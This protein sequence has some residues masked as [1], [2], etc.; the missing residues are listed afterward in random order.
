MTAQFSSS[1]QYCC[2]LNC[3]FRC[4]IPLWLIA[5][6]KE[7]QSLGL[8]ERS[9]QSFS[10][11]DLGVLDGPPE[12]GFDVVVALSAT[13]LNAPMVALVMIDDES[14]SIFLRAS[15][16]LSRNI[17]PMI[18]LPLTGS[19]ASETRAENQPVLINDL[20]RSDNTHAVEAVFLGAGA[21][22]GAPVHG[23][24]GEPIGA[25]LAMHRT[26][27]AWTKAQAQAVEGFA[28]LT[29]QHIM[30]KASFETLRLMKRHRGTPYA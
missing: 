9:G 22:L 6:V 18:G 15:I 23:P 21:C 20:A 10:P 13:A 2:L 11:R 3:D 17:N 24:A 28:Y 27:N 26:S 8:E 25:L 1:I 29:S 16:G 19:V 5:L 14:A 30:L 7:G 12:K 4:L